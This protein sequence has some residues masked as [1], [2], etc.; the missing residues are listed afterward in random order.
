[1]NNFDPA[2]PSAGCDRIAVAGSFFGSPEFRLKGIYVFNFYQV[3]FNGRLPAYAEIILDMRAVTGQTSAEVFQKRAQFAVAFT[4]RAEFRAL[5]DGLSDAAYVSALLSRYGVTTI[6]S[7]DPA[8]PDGN[9]FV[10]LTQT[11]LSN[12][13]T[14]GTLTRAHVLRAVV[15]SREVGAREFNRAFVAMQY[16]GYLRRTPET[17]GFNA[18]LTYL[19]AHP[20]EFRTLTNGFVNSTEYRLR[21]GRATP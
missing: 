1:V 21:F 13:L 7:P 4:Q 14:A 6:T 11:E 2:S 8:T 20:T 10:T 15:E 17:S 19:N 9:Q 12:Q 16:Y 5:Y 18:W 3:A